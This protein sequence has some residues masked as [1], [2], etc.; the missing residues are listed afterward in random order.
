MP[1]EHELEVNVKYGDGKRYVEL[2]PGETIIRN[3]QDAVELV[4]ICGEN[5]IDRILLNE[6]DLTKDFFDL[7]TL[8]AGNI[9]QKFMTYGIKVA[10]VISDD[11][12]KGR[13]KEMAIEANQGNNFRI[14]TDKS[15][16]EKWL[17]NS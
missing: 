15:Q 2:V 4:G 7:K 9:L 6:K 10:L 12:I 14:F 17:I 16:A 1:E 5:D 3:E 13:F 11:N 8:F